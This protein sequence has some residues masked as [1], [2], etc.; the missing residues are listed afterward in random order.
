M[1]LEDETFEAFGYY[2]SDLKPRS[3]KPIIA[4][5]EL[6]GKIRIIA[7]E[8]YRTFCKSCS[9]KGTHRSDEAR[10]KMSDAQKGAKN[11]N[12]GNPMSEEQ[13]QKISESGKGKQAGRKNP[14]YDKRGAESS[15]YKGGLKLAKKRT[16]AKRRTLGSTFLLV[17]RPGEVGHHISNECIIGAPEEVHRKFSG[18]SREEHK[19]RMLEWFRINDLVKYQI[20]IKAL[21]TIEGWI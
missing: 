15:N 17:L 5:C 19:T 12:Y 10:Q 13:K 14:N 11:H 2:A 8:D 7:Q 16:N 6:C 3:N 20:C 1:I 4:A 21:R 18:Y 9:R